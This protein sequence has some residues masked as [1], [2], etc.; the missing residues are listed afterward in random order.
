M[1]DDEYDLPEMLVSILITLRECPKEEF[2][3]INNF[4]E[5][6]GIPMPD[7]S[8]FAFSAVMSGALALLQNVEN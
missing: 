4:F 7:R 5:I 2:P 3:S 1:N 8:D 6:A